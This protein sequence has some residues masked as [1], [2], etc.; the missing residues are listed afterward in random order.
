MRNHVNLSCCSWCHS[1]LH[2]RRSYSYLRTRPNI[3][4]GKLEEAGSLVVRAINIE[5]N[6]LGADHP[7]VAASICNLAVLVWSQ[8][9]IAICRAV[10]YVAC[11]ERFLLIP[12]LYAVAAHN[13][14]EIF[15]CRKHEST[16]AACSTSRRD[17]QLLRNA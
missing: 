14:R 6:T 5:E 11:G 9:T 8:V 7:E 15:C 3:T 16:S 13:V 1:R 17:T 2:G 10:W 4:Q 12:R